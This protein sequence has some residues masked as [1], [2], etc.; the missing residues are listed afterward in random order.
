MRLCD[1]EGVTVAAANAS[2]RLAEIALALADASGLESTCTALEDG[3]LRRESAEA[4][5][6]F[7]A[8]GNTTVESC[9]RL[10]QEAWILTAPELSG[11][12]LALVLRTSLSSLT[13]FR[14]R[15]PATQIVWT[16]PKVDGSFL[17]ATREVVREIL[18]GV[19]S[20]LLIVGYW[21]A[22]REDGDGIIEEIIDLLADAVRRG[23]I[24]TVVVDERVRSDGRD[25]RRIL[26][27]AWPSSVTLPHIL[28]WRL[29]PDD[30]HLK[31]HAKV[32]VAD[33][34]DA[35]VT[36]ANLTSYAMDRNM[37]MG[38]RIVGQPAYDIAK[39]F[40]LLAR[41]GV[42]ESYGEEQ[43]LP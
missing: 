37:E 23:V 14:R 21:I 29:P 25:N 26:V 27:T 16:G 33:Q 43:V 2:V 31:L 32:L 22:A 13:T 18:R 38:V 17:R 10:L 11:E 35:L 39:H 3:Q 7:L 6:A 19:R 20:E 5:R 12:A 9:L 34:R 24:V 40:N 41:S 30:Q 1:E 8:G 4:V 28:T 36:S 42:L 15:V